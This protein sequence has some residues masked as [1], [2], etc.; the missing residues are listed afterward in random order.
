MIVRYSKGAVRDLE[1]ALRS[2]NITEKQAI[3]VSQ[4]SDISLKQRKNKIAYLFF[5][6]DPLILY[7]LEICDQN[8]RVINNHK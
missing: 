1:S 2:K 4:L 6:D 8:L 3:F 5:R 7:F